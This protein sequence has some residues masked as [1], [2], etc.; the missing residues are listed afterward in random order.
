MD[1]M[2]FKPGDSVLYTSP[3][4]EWESIVGRICDDEIHLHEPARPGFV[5][6]QVPWVCLPIRADNLKI[7]TS[8]PHIQKWIEE[9]SGEGTEEWL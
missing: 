9:L 4:A 2:I 3:F 5:N 7:Y 6:F 1:R 8:P